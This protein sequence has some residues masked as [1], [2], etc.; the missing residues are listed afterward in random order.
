MKRILCI[1]LALAMVV[2]CFLTSAPS[3]SADERTA[4]TYP[5]LSLKIHRIQAVDPIDVGSE[6]DWCYWIYDPETSEI[7][8]SAEPIATND[9]D[10]IVDITH[11]FTVKNVTTL[12]NILLFD[13][14]SPWSDDLA[15]IS[16]YAGGGAD[17]ASEVTR[18]AMYFGSYDLRTDTL[19]LDTTYTESGYYKT[20][21]DYDG[22]TSTDENDANVWFD[23]W[24]NYDTPTANAGS[25]QTVYT[26]N[27]VNFNGGSSYASTG[28]SLTKYQW[29]FNNDGTYD[30]EGATT[31]YTYS[32]K[33]VY[34]V[35]L[36]VTDSIGETDTDTCVVTVQNRVPT[37]AF[38]YSPSSPTTADTIQFTDTSTD[39]DGTI[40]SWSWIF[41]DGT[42]STSK[43][44]THKYSDDGTY[45]VKLTATDNNGGTDMESKLITVLNVGP[46][47]DFTYSPTS[48]T[49]EDN[50]QFTDSS[51]DSDGSIAS[52]SWVFGDGSVSTLQNPTHQYSIA[53]SYTVT[54]TVTDDDG[55]TATDTV[56]VTVTEKGG[57]ISFD[58]WAVCCTIIIV[59]VAVI[60][61]VVIMLTRRKKALP[62]PV[63][64]TPQ[65]FQS[66]YTPPPTPT[67]PPVVTAPTPPPTPVPKPAVAIK[68]PHCGVNVQM[69]WKACPACGNKLPM[70]CPQC[71]AV[72]QEG[73]KACPKCG[74]KFS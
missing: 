6:A 23:V 49:T 10:V 51:T 19:T 73:W 1:G 38:T 57:G 7:I 15:D 36:K 35:T 48:P 30:A 60:I 64:P 8:K 58:S 59:I 43:D 68:C 70:C 24:D 13:D 18:G 53:S 21:G 14:D 32:T 41:G 65:P 61:V 66:P 29:D 12:I 39:S 74:E 45:T 5:T 37:S 69:G 11:E 34:I 16:S 67:Q 55:A 63:A 20:S 27:L 33:G 46:T 40:A 9:D 3:V 22:S 31:S 56:T 71:G 2:G 28:S 50:I 25:D 17:D 54:L 26:G 52:W 42:T 4:E 47:T 62:P 44:P 72:V